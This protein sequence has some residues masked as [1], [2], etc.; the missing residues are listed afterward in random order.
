LALGLSPLLRSRL[1]ARPLPSTVDPGVLVVLTEMAGDLTLQEW[2]GV[3]GI[4][5]WQVLHAC[6]HLGVE[7]AES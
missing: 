1:S 7:P 5:A 3:L 6:V 4:P 2:S